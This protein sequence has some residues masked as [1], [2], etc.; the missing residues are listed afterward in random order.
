MRRYLLSFRVSERVGVSRNRQEPRRNQR[1]ILVWS[2]RLA[3]AGDEH[4]M[5]KRMGAQGLAFSK[6]AEWP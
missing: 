2:K 1:Q 4:P 6:P 5:E 3:G